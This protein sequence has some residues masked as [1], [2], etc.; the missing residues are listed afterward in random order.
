MLLL[1]FVSEENTTMPLEVSYSPVSI[2][3][4][5]M[6]L[7]FAEAMK[8]MRTLGQCRAPWPAPNRNKTYKIFLFLIGFS[9]KEFDDIKGIF[10]DTNLWL[11][12]MT[13]FVSFFHVSQRFNFIPR[14]PSFVSGE[15][16]NETKPSGSATSAC[17]N[18]TIPSIAVIRFLGFQ[19]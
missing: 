8:T 6:W 12:G 3:L 4:L 17:M 19:K 14:P 9:D 7:H 16:G 1:Q 10:L 2:G 5:R 18:C 13:I 11:L 15:S